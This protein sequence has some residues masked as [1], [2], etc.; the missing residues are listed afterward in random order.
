MTDTFLP[1]VQSS[2]KQVTSSCRPRNRWTRKMTWSSQHAQERQHPKTLTSR[3]SWS[4]AQPPFTAAFYTL[5]TYCSVLQ[6]SCQKER[7]TKGWERIVRQRPAFPPEMENAQRR[8]TC[9]SA[10]PG[11][12]ETLLKCGC[13]SRVSQ[14][15]QRAF[16]LYK[17][18]TQS[19]QFKQHCQGEKFHFAVFPWVL[20]TNW[21]FFV[22]EQTRN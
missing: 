7:G 16:L 21:I 2:N 4:L 8:N 22:L 19:Q 1:Q 6:R 20:R 13:T 15:I 12:L 18:Q 17:N 3:K 11:L 5:P 14:H 9:K 10:R